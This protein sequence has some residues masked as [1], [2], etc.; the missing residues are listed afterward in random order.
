M[1]LCMIADAM[2]RNKAGCTTY[3]GRDVVARQ[4]QD[5]S[6]S[7][8]FASINTVTLLHV[9]SVVPTYSVK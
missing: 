9:W 3:A 4:L 5:K 2:L 6:R 7:A 8:S 1:E